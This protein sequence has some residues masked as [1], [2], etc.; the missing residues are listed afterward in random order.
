[1]E[2]GGRGKGRGEKD[3]AGRG[4]KDMAGHGE[5]DMARRGVRTRW[6][7][8]GVTGWKAKTCGNRDRV[9]QELQK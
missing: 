2:H 1:M 9:Y 8:E 5:K 3:M 4:E 6:I 7:L